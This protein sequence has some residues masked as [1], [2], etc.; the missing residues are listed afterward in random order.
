M[1][2][3]P[4]YQTNKASLCEQIADLVNSKQIEARSYGSPPPGASTRPLLNLT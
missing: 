4:C 2:V 1:N 3:R